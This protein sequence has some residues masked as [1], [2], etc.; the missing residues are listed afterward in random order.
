MAATAP[1]KKSYY[2]KELTA[3]VDPPKE[4][5][6]VEKMNDQLISPLQIKRHTISK[7]GRLQVV[8]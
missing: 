1:L 5:N 2:M 7:N 4:A 3:Q 6:T 8:F